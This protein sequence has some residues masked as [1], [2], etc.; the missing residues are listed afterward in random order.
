MRTHRVKPH[1]KG[2]GTEIPGYERVSQGRSP[3]ASARAADIDTRAR[4]AAADAS[5]NE[6]EV[7]R[8]PSLG[9]GVVAVKTSHIMT[10]C[11]SHLE[12][13]F[14]RHG[15]DAGDH[16]MMQLLR[17]AAGD[18]PDRLALVAEFDSTPPSQRRS[19]T[20]PQNCVDGR[21]W[22]L[23]TDEFGQAVID[24]DLLE[25]SGDEYQRAWD[26]CC[27]T[28]SCHCNMENWECIEALL[29]NRNAPAAEVHVEHPTPGFDVADNEHVYAGMESPWGPVQESGIEHVVH[30]VTS[31]Q[32]AGHG[33]LHLSRAAWAALPQAVRSTFMTPGW[34]EQDCE[35][36][37]ALAVLGI[38]GERRQAI[39]DSARGIAER[40]DRY[41]PCLAH[42][43]EGSA[44][45]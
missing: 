7:L 36:Q 43:P 15:H 21:A 5:A 38:G 17:A 16:E 26:I 12:G 39:A 25:Y 2:D 24:Q 28:D 23:V 18:D 4:A 45:G 6:G 9:T 27:P 1:K 33:G 32:A 34:A 29:T 20:D 10:I 13:V 8:H 19:E 14:M 30:G 37:I 41:A 44:A 3:K 22:T 42:I 35:E 40:F 31:V 11:E